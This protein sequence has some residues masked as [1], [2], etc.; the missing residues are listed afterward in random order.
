[1]EESDTQTG[2]EIRRPF[3]GPAFISKNLLHAE[4]PLLYSALRFPFG[5]TA[6]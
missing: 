6:K 5:D 4:L 1:M 2:R 3:I